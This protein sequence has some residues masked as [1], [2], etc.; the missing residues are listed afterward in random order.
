MAKT[1][2]KEG[3][4]LPPLPR[5]QRRLVCPH[6]KLGVGAAQRCLIPANYTAHE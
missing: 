5:E 2:A 4:S 1:S 3:A 6:R